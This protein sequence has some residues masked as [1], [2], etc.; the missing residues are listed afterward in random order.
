MVLVTRTGVKVTCYIALVALCNTQPV[1]ARECTAPTTSSSIVA[2]SGYAGTADGPATSAR[3]ILPSALA[4]DQKGELYV[5]DSAAQRVRVIRR[6]GTV[7]TVA[8]S[9]DPIKGSLWVIPGF[10]N[11]PTQQARF[12]RPS[13]IALD[14]SGNIYI[15]D[16]DN[17]CIRLIK[18]GMV[19]TFAD[20]CGRAGTTDGSRET[21][22]FSDPHQM[23]FS[24]DG[25]LYVA[26]TGNGVRAIKPNGAVST[27]AIPDDK[28]ATGITFEASNSL[29]VADSKGLVTVDL[30]NM[31]TKRVT[32]AQIE[33]AVEIGKPFSLAGGTQE[34]DLFYTDL[35]NDSVQLLSGGSQIQYVT[36]APSADAVLGNAWM[37]C[38]SP[39]LQGPMAVLQHDGAIYV[40][41]SGHKQILRIN[42]F[43]EQRGLV[44]DPTA[45]LG[46]L[47]DKS[48]YTILVVG[49][50][51]VWFNSNR[52][53]SI[54][55]N[56]ASRLNA[57]HALRR[58]GKTLRII[59]LRNIADDIFG[60]ASLAKEI[61]SLS[62]VDMV[63]LFANSVDV[64]EFIGRPN[65][66]Q[67]FFDLENKTVKSLS[68]AGIKTV[69]VSIPPASQVTPLEQIYNE[70]Q[71]RRTTNDYNSMESFLV[72]LLR[73][74]GAPIFS[75][76]PLV[77]EY[78]SKPFIQPLYSNS[79]VHPSL[80]GRKFFGDA[81]ARELERLQPWASSK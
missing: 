62:N 61:I 57:D 10:K 80:Y 64:G 72:P 9:G 5:T 17:H 36:G 18:N 52:S 37:G 48:K 16:T 44:T 11:G 26:D 71:I 74:T 33:G 21:A 24:A 29:A 79:D 27:L 6:N 45:L 35:R 47:R 23:A 8:G 68:D 2:G 78:E 14:G 13:G 75:L 53:N 38:S 19:S 40:A 32:D 49:N 3:F 30:R 20:V 51:F 34:G 66:Q 63:L 60:Q 31:K 69:F 25:T 77:Q 28:A 76:Y 67:Q 65:W 70:E 15:A 50:S 12:N 58:T 59:E 43:E 73:K 81:I 4:I 55:A 42:G 7:A 41:D 39:I 54:A 22:T 56:I 1:L 46:M